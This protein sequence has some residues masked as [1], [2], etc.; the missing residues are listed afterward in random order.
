[1]GCG[2]STAAA[3][4]P[5]KYAAPEPSPQIHAPKPAAETSA[6]STAS[7]TTYT[8]AADRTINFD[9]FLSHNPESQD[10]AA[11]VN[12]WL[13]ESGYKAFLDD[14]KLDVS[15]EEAVQT[16]RLHVRG[17]KFFVAFLTPAY[18][19]T[20]ESCVEFCEAVVRSVPMVLIVVDGS[21]WDGKRF[22]AIT[23]VPE[24]HDLG[25]GN[26]LKLRDAATAA[27]ASAVRLEHTRA[28]FDAFLKQF[29][30]TLGPP[31]EGSVT[32]ADAKEL[33]RR[34]RPRILERRLFDAPVASISRSSLQIRRS[35]VEAPAPKATD[36]TQ[37]E[38]VVSVVCQGSDGATS[39]GGVSLVGPTT[40]ASDVRQ[41]IIEANEEDE[42]DEDEREPA[43]KLL[44]EGKF[45][46]ARRDG[47]AP[48]ALEHEASVAAVELGDPIHVKL[49]A[50]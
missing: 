28:Y 34:L 47:A 42:E 23:D 25:D 41:Q 11:R 46:F 49:T 48:L 3:A 50:G 21:L 30:A 27:F 32:A 22:P 37:A 17:S 6:A 36:T 8:L 18:F 45:V 31:V 10:T 29:K 24:E 44:G 20:S 1:M 26:K 7:S 39:D 33:V 40:M 4:T 38:K 15:S 35:L 14:N 2:A 9:A 5:A 19:S 43:A 13:L 12:D 16:Q